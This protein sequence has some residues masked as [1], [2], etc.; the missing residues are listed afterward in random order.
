M[1]VL[2]LERAVCEAVDASAPGELLLSLPLSPQ[3]EDDRLRSRPTP[4]LAHV[5]SRPQPILEHQMSPPCASAHGGTWDGLAMSPK[6]SGYVAQQPHTPGLA[7]SRMEA[8][9]PGTPAILQP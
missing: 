2:P 4:I 8:G 1:V 5:Q 9:E 6:T 7:A 3:K